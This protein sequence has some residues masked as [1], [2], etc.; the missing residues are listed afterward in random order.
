MGPEW[1]TALQFGTPALV[2][3]LVIAVARLIQSVNDLKAIVHDMGKNV[4]W[5]GTCTA[6]HDGLSMRM[7][8]V[9]KA[10]NGRMGTG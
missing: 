9:E 7:A 5:E 8:R 2:F 3:A 1:V 6:K 10:M 4:M